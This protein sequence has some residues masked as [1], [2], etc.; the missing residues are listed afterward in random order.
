VSFWGCRWWLCRF[1]QHLN[2]QTLASLF[3]SPRICEPATMQPITPTNRIPSAMIPTRQCLKRFGEFKKRTPL[4]MPHLPSDQK[5]VSFYF[6]FIFCYFFFNQMKFLYILIFLFFFYSRTKNGYS[7][8]V[9]IKHVRFGNS[10]KT[11]I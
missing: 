8:C 4:I 11:T 1:S 2:H 10:S 7:S 6:C 9:V 5:H 3:Y